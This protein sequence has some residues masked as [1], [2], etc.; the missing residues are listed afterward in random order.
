MSRFRPERAN[1]IGIILQ[2]ECTYRCAHCLYACRPGLNETIRPV[3]LTPGFFYKE[4]ARLFG[5]S[6]EKDASTSEI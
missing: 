2:Y 1:S 6:K 5:L 3:E 4:M